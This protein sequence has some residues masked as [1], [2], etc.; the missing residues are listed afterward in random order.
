MYVEALLIHNFIMYIQILNKSTT[1]YIKNG[2]ENKHTTHTYTYI[3]K[4]KLKNNS[5]YNSLITYIQMYCVDVSC[6]FHMVERLRWCVLSFLVCAVTR[7]PIVM[8]WPPLRVSTDCQGKFSLT[9]T[10]CPSVIA[11]LFAAS[12]PLSDPKIKNVM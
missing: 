4:Y 11:T 12:I 7:C 1:A 2:Q 3:P 6:V 10:R 8:D 5:F 9:L